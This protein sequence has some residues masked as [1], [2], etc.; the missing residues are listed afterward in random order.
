MSGQR[1]TKS[2]CTSFGVHMGWD[3]STTKYID[4]TVHDD[5]FVW[6]VV[7][8]GQLVWVLLLR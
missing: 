3:G 2:Q 7:S 6:F 5:L 8:R 1:R 4:I